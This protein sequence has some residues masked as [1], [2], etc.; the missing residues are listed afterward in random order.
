MNK[1]ENEFCPECGHHLYK[2]GDDYFCVECGRSV[3]ADDVATFEQVQFLRSDYD[4]EA[5][6]LSLDS[7]ED[8]KQ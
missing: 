1:C 8:S 4:E 5:R 2:N 3:S 7:E 6:R